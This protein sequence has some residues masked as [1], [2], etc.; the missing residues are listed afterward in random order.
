[1]ICLEIKVNLKKCDFCMGKKY[2]SLIYYCGKGIK[3]DEVKVKAIKEWHTSK[4]V[5][6]VRSFHGLTSFYIRFVKDFSTTVAPLTEIVKKTISFKWE[7]EQEKTFN[8]LKDKLISASLL[9]RL[10]LPKLLRLNVIL[11]V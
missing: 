7:F 11:Q 2:F 4:T 8:L 3:I 9:F 5:S 6:K 10:T 1:M